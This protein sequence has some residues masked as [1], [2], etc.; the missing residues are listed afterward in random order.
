MELA[1]SCF[2][3]IIEISRHF[4]IAALNSQFYIIYYD[5]NERKIE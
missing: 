1:F 3:Y 2:V 5:F 4:L